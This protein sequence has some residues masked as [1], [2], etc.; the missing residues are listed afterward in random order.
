MNRYAKTLRWAL[1]AAGI[2]L[3]LLAVV[4]L[5]IPHLLNIDSIRQ[6]VLTEVSRKVGGKV[7][8]ERVGVAL[9]PLPHLSIYQGRLAIPEVVRG[10]LESLSV[11]PEIFPLLTGK[12]R[13]RRVSIER[14][15]FNLDFSGSGRP[16]EARQAAEPGGSLAE[17]VKLLVAALSGLGDDLALSIRRGR[18]TVLIRKNE[19]WAVQ[20]MDFDFGVADH[21]LT[22][23]G[24]AESPGL[25]QKA[26]LT[27]EL[28]FNRL[29][30]HGRLTLTQL[31][32]R[33]P[34]SHLIPD[35]VMRVGK[36]LANLDL[37]FSADGAGALEVE[38]LGSLPRLSL[39][40]RG[41]ETV[42]GV[43]K[44]SGSFYRDPEKT[45]VSLKE[46]DLENPRAV[47]TGSFS[48]DKIQT[49]TNLDISGREL[50]VE[51][52][53]EA[54]LK[55]AGD[56]AVVP[57]IFDILK[58]GRIPAIRFSIS[59]DTPGALNRLDRMSIGGSLQQGRIRVPGVDLDVKAVGGSVT[60]TQGVLQVKDIV[61]EYEG[62]RVVDGKLRLGLSSGEVPFSLDLGL[63]ADL[64]P[65]PGVLKK[66][67]KGDQRVFQALDRFT[68][69]RGTASAR[70]HIGERLD[71]IKTAVQVDKFKVSANMQPDSLPLEISG[72]GLSFTGSQL[73]VAGLDVVSRNSFVSLQ[74]AAVRWD[75]T[76]TVEIRTGSGGLNIGELY[77]LLVK[78]DK[79][80]EIFK[81]HRPEQGVV[82]LSSFDFAAP[83]DDLSQGPFHV[84]GTLKNL[85]VSSDRLPD[86]LSI[87][88][89]HFKLTPG[90]FIFTELDTKALDAGLNISGRFRW[91]RQGLAD[92]AMS[93]R[94]TIGAQAGDW[95]RGRVALPPQ[96]LIRP[97]LTI[98]GLQL[99]WERGGRLSVSGDLNVNGDLNFYADVRRQPGRFEVQKFT[100][101]DKNS[102]AEISLHL[103][104][105]EVAFNFK[106]NLQK[107]TVDKFYAGN[108]V[109]GGWIKGDLRLNYVKDQPLAS[110]FEGWL[111][112]K[113]FPL[114]SQINFPAKIQSL[115][116]EGQK[117]ALTLRSEIVLPQDRQLVLQA[118]V[119]HSPSGI[120][121][122]ADLKSDGLVLDDFSKAL[123]QR[124]EKGVPEK[125]KPAKRFWEFPLEGRLRLESA[126]LS[127]GHYRW[128]T[129]RSQILLQP[130]RISITLD[131]ANLCGIATPGTAILQPD[132]ILLDFRPQ[133]KN[134]DLH[135]AAV[136]LADKDTR[137]EGSFDLSGHIVGA[138]PAAELA[139][140]LQGEFDLTA[141]KGRFYSGGTYGI[142]KD[143]LTLVNVTEIYRGK[144]SD[145]GKE[146]FGYNS[147]KARGIYRNEALTI[148]EGFIDGL[149]LNLAASGNVNFKT[150][151]MDIKALAAPLK[152][153][154]AIVD[155][156]PLVGYIL[157]GTL[158][159]VPVRVS[160]GLDTPEV[161]LME[162]SAI[163]EGLMG[164]MKRTFN[165]PVKIFEP[166]FSKE[167][168]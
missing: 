114:I 84:A 128:Q 159:T 61:A 43:K 162:P 133:A 85:T 165:L 149:L 21:R 33:R 7:E 77:P 95:V 108:E 131:E 134:Q 144:I 79:L 109:L 2:L 118:D 40:R 136:C 119:E 75:K 94:G 50:A 145:M 12:L 146:G 8:I 126:Y 151:Q 103:G 150:R 124:K 154:D 69:I 59:G 115:S 55:L 86:R 107:S 155:K 125:K 80:R 42:I 41:E 157:G 9:W 152:T 112:I 83:L 111:S 62:S 16:D 51:A 105:K 68:G 117:A 101:Q 44:L 63:Q 168:K 10:N 91:D 15:D 99:A 96:L 23:H 106:G 71:Q 34:A 64:G 76:P 6:T 30:T 138:G 74:A 47:L 52:V 11:Y 143:I 88:R 4:V 1:Y 32:P 65:L 53:R 127:Y 137:I 29:E 3:I 27:A 164:I 82:T 35:G 92:S 156:I 167:K 163:G 38:V 141:G 104:Q 54:V 113:D 98:S 142:L 81:H 89:G 36:S 100:I 57:K 25:F 161:T 14:P 37:K 26:A 39:S 139:S 132:Q 153:V 60:V 120:V 66:I 13:I 140:S 20:Q 17:K 31:D 166:L 72:R 45:R 67:V 56:V 46:L 110:A 19:E 48:F 129:V 148:Q 5:T 121:F 102:H 22:V 130:D 28:D 24:S 135:A 73:E 70:L 147:I 160:G 122:D 58:G 116:I 93:V 18:L 78:N 90:E 49:K 158:I 97:P 87:G 123:A